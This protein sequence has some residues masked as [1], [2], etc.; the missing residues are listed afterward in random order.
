MATFIVRLSEKEK[1]ELLKYGSISEG[2]REGIQLYVKAKRRREIM[3]ELDELQR[4]NPV[5]IS[6]S[7]IVRSIREDRDR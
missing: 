7:E 2:H 4:K 5:E 1:K 6:S 3:R